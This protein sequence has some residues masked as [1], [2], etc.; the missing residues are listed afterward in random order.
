MTSQTFTAV[1][2]KEEDMYVAECPEVG[3]AS[4]G[5]TIEEAVANLREAT[6]VYL[7]EFPSKAGEC[8][9]EGRCNQM[10]DGVLP[11]VFDQESWTH[12][13]DTMLEEL[14]ENLKNILALELQLGNSVERIDRPAGSECPLAVA[15]KTPLHHKELQECG[16]F[17]TVE[18]WENR[19][20][21]Y[22]LETGYWCSETKQS[23]SGPLR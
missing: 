10:T 22:P 13:K 7:V 5:A 6:E 16:N 15:M 18:Y 23:I 11:S 19:D 8:V 14:S 20:S 12:E 3:T 4:Q 1:L 21:H 17:G 9:T 2:H